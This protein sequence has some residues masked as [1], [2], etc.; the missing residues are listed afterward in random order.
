VREALGGA[1]LRIYATDDV[2]GAEFAATGVGL[3]AMAVG[4]ARGFGLG[5][6]TLAVMATRG[7]SECAR[8]GVHLGGRVETFAGLAGHGDLLAAVAGDDRPELAVGALLAGE[9]G[10][11]PLG[12]HG[13]A[14]IEGLASARRIAAYTQRHGIRAPLLSLCADVFE[15]KVSG[16]EAVAALMGRQVGDE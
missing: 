1:R 15:R 5:P 13:G 14:F 8:I 12:G 10:P 2:V 3:L 9:G 6:A 16:H 7:M 4:F 11:A